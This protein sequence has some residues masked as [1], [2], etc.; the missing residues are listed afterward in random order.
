MALFARSVTPWRKGDKA[1][2][3]RFN[4]A[5]FFPAQPDEMELWPKGGGAQLQV[6]EGSGQYFK[7]MHEHSFHAGNASGPVPEKSKKS[8]RTEFLVGTTLYRGYQYLPAYG[9]SSL[10]KIL[11][12]LSEEEMAALIK[13]G[14]RATWPKVP[15][16]R[17]TTS[18]GRTLDN[19]LHAFEV[20]EAHWLRSAP[21]TDAAL[22]ANSK[23]PQTRRKATQARRSDRAAAII[24]G[25]VDTMVRV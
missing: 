15:A 2:S 23:K 24:E 6:V 8:I 9:L 10:G 1:G 22:N 18:I 25:K 19:I 4:T 5:D 7:Q 14:E 12:M 17:Q 21:Q 13:A 20:D 16:I 3:G 11:K